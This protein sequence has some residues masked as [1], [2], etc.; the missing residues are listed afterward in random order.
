M[1]LIGVFY[2][3]DIFSIFGE[4]QDYYENQNIMKN[5]TFITSKTYLSLRKQENFDFWSRLLFSHFR[6]YAAI[7][8]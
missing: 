7:T 1:A 4:Y 5:R 8:F 3:L 6:R 2:F